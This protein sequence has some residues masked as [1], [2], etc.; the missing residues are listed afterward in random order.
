MDSLSLTSQDDP[1]RVGVLSWGR[2]PDPAAKRSIVSDG[3]PYPEMVRLLTDLQRK[4]A[5]DDR[6]A[7]GT[8]AHRC[9][10]VDATFGHERPGGFEDVEARLVSLCWEN[11]PSAKP[12]A[13]QA[14]RSCIRLTAWW[15]MRE[16]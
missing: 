3:V 15:W 10:A 13:I 2:L 9:V 6:A 1:D 16:G 7:L 5:A 12:G 8:G 14:P 4:S 11:L